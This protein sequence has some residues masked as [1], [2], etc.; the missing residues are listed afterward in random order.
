MEGG[1]DT[2]RGNEG[3]RHDAKMQGVIEQKSYLDL[4]A[5]KTRNFSED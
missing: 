5:Q 1:E 2:M 4:E 3:G